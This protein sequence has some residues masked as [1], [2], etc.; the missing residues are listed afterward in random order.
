MQ[1]LQN[2][3]LLSSDSTAM[4][5]L[6]DFLRQRREAPAAVEDFECF[7]QEVHRFFVAAEREALGHELARFDLDVPQVEVEGERYNRV[8]RCETTYNSAAGPVRVARSLYRSA[9][10]GE[11]ICPLELDA[12]IIEGYW[13]SLAAKQATWAVSHLT[14]QE[15]AELFELI[16]NM[17][18][19]KSPLDR[20]PKALSAH[21]EANRPRFEGALRT[22]ETVPPEAVSMA[23]SLDGVMV[24]MKEGK[25]QAKR[26]G[27]RAKGKSPSG[28]SGY[29]E[30]G[31]GTV[32]YYDRFGER[33]VTRRMARMPETNKA[34]LKSQL[35][36][37]VI[38]ALIERP[39]LR[40]VK[41]ADGAADNWIYLRATFPF[42]DEVL[43]F[44]H[45]SDHL[46]EALQAAYKEGTPTYQER[47]TTL[48]EVLRDVPQGVDNVIDAL[49]RLRSR[50]PRRQAIHKTIA[51]F[52]EHRHRMRYSDL[53][54]QFLPI[55][56]GVVEAACKSLVAQRLKR[57]G[58]RWRVPGG[59][60]ILTF[61]ALCQSERF[62]RAW[63]LLVETY[64]QT[65]TLPHK[66]IALS[67]HH[68]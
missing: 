64:K 11:A 66:V 21:W 34:T 56:S 50:Y 18:P 17:T 43:D 14:P 60:A 22:Q 40:V 46:R 6:Q 7:E 27:A 20:L 9:R 5:Q 42:G 2:Q 12:G 51:Y 31:C 15:S 57:S 58:M 45:A 61:R 53:R 19:S 23:V 41:V 30:V 35:T 26:Q 10:G 33:L 8:L 52:R 28:P 32:S 63:P 24:P 3:D 68:K 59:Q 36:H 38:G 25:R 62:E 29:Q 37:E 55:G 49:C 54:E 44:Y 67:K 13:T 39:D 16:G 65:V 4:D 48:S 1:A 47:L